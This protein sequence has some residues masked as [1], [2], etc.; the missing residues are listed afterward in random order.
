MNGQKPLQLEAFGPRREQGDEAAGPGTG[1]QKQGAVSKGVHTTA[2]AVPLQKAAWHPGRG[3][4]TVLH[5]EE[6]GFAGLELKRGMIWGHRAQEEAGSGPC[7]W[8]CGCRASWGRSKLR[9]WNSSAAE[10][11]Q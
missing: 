1:Q 2:D 3:H 11:S 7:G 9:F 5:P 10:S 8:G 4:R 6:E